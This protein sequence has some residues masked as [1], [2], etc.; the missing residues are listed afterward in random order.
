MKLFGNRKN[1]EHVAKRETERNTTGNGLKCWQ[2]G[3][4]IAV[5]VVALLSGVAYGVY[6]ANV[7]PPVKQLEP[8][9]TEPLPEEE[10]VKKPTVTI[11]AVQEDE[12]TGE[13]V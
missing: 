8:E 7:K 12:E 13:Q 9:Q 6:K 5:A 1:A 2:K 10:T 3:V 11:P 4:I